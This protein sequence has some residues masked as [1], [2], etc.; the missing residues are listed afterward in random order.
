MAVHPDGLSLSS[1][2]RGTHKGKGVGISSGFSHP[3]KLCTLVRGA[4]SNN[5]GPRPDN[6]AVHFGSLGKGPRME[7]HECEVIPLNLLQC[8]TVFWASIERRAESHF[9]AI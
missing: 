5:C 9:S 2:E 1:G 4:G 8:L 6:F 3:E 7:D